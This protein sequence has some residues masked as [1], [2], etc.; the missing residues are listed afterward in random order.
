MPELFAPIEG[1][2]QTEQP[3]AN[4]SEATETASSVVANEPIQQNITNE[5]TETASS[6]SSFVPDEYREAGWVKRFGD[7]KEAFFKSMAN[8]Q[9][10]LGRKNGIPDFEND[11]PEIINQFRE[12]L[13][14]PK[15]A[16]E[17]ELPDGFE[18]DENVN[19]FLELAHKGHMPKDVARDMLNLYNSQVQNILEQKTQEQESQVDEVFREFAQDPKYREISVNVRNIISKVDPTG[20]LITEQTL[21]ELGVNAPKIAR[22]LDRIATLTGDDKI[23]KNDNTGIHTGSREE[24]IQKIFDDYRSKRISKETANARREAINKMYFN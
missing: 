4:T 21:S 23:I 24:Q 15:T 14:V 11:P 20:E 13:G 16:D 7:D 12:N 8:A 2:T 6:L 9:K 10:M 22:F 19:S 18:R 1:E 17:Y 5:A 3:Q